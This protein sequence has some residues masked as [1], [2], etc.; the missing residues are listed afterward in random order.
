MTWRELLVVAVPVG[1]ILAALAFALFL[2]LPGENGSRSRA[3]PPSPQIEV[4][5]PVLQYGRAAMWYNFTVE[6][7][8]GSPSWNSTVVWVA[9]GWLGGLNSDSSVWVVNES[10]GIVA[11]FLN[12]SGNWSTS[13]PAPVLVGQVLSL[14]VPHLL[15]DAQFALICKGPPATSWGFG[16]LP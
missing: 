6:Q 10:G 5:Q 7:V 3:G 12:V 16:A 1:L 14:K 2:A 15:T 4:T 13:S 8:L 9:G 11:N